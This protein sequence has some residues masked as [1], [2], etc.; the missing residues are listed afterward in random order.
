[1]ANFVGL[2]GGG[3][4]GLDALVSSVWLVFL[5]NIGGIDTKGK[6]CC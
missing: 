3:W 2:G 5:A 6:T 1:M 4:G